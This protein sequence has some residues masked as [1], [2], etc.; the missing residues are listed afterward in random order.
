MKTILKFIKIWYQKVLSSIAFYPIL[1]GFLF[2]LLA[3]VSL[4]LE[5]IKLISEF[6]SNFSFLFIQ[7]KETSQT[8]LSTLIGGILSLTV[9]SFSM[10]MVVLNQASA[11]YSPRLLPGLI[12]DKRNQL[13]LGFYIGTL[14]YCMIILIS[15]GAYGVKTNSFG[16]ST[17]IS[18]MLSIA[19]VGF[20][21]YFIHSISRTIQINTIIKT[22]FR[23]SDRSLNKA[24]KEQSK[25]NTI[26]IPKN[27]QNKESIT[28]NTTGYYKDFD[29]SFL[30]QSFIKNNNILEILV[31]QNQKTW[32]GETIAKINTNLSEEAI[33]EI[34]LCF[35]IVNDRLE[36]ENSV[37]NMVKLTEIAVRAL[38]PGVNDPGTAIDVINYVGILL[39][40]AAQLTDTYCIN[41]KGNL[42]IIHHNVPFKEIF[43]KVIQPIRLYAKSDASV[44]Y[45]LISMLTHLMKTAKSAT[46]NYEPIV[47]NEL[48]NIK[49]DIETHISNP[50]DLKNLLQAMK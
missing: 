31:H 5:S 39:K 40:K 15:L 33:K 1:I 47:T 11:N 37:S 8:I 12:S 45:E 2:F 36:S 34:R 24:I 20:F 16:L 50:D 6:K 35:N 17:M 4:S 25:E 18:A 48:N 38:S 22:L 44:M 26:A 28:A 30:E 13:I 49:N 32:E 3:V 10:V 23:K 29:S 7:D 27:I 21:V 43:R 41:P 14:T 9:F 19:C 46:T 42:K